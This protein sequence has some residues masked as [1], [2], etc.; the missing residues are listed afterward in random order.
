M[1]RRQRQR[2]Q[3][4]WK[5][6]AQLY[7]MGPMATDQVPSTVENKLG[8][9]T[10]KLLKWWCPF[11]YDCARDFGLPLTLLRQPRAPSAYLPRKTHNKKPNQIK[12]NIFVCLYFYGIV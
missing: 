4:R 8:E 5:Q 3:L 7:Y 12:S 6:S 1:F 11:D 9:K 10:M 2:R